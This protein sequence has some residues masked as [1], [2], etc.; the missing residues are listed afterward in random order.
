MRL[1]CP[2]GPALFT[3]LAPYWPTHR[4]L[5]PWGQPERYYGR[6][7]YRDD[8]GG[9]CSTGEGPCG[10]ADICITACAGWLTPHARRHP[11]EVCTLSGG[12]MSQPL[13]GR[14]PAGVRLLP[15]PLPAA[16]SVGLAASLP[17]GE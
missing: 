7:G 6:A 1:G 12:V 13:S 15:R 3:S 8:F 17:V 10:P 2:L 14:L 4:E 11:G 5:L 9:G 16:P